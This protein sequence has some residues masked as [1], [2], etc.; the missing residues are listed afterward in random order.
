MTT[1]DSEG[2]HLPTDPKTTQKAKRV[3][4][5]SE[6]LRTGVE[7]FSGQIIREPQAREK[8]NNASD[9]FNRGREN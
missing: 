5:Y 4:R 8:I 1:K 3:L 2:G 7:P 6:A 9:E